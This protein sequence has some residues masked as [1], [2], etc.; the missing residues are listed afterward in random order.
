LQQQINELEFKL[1]NVSDELEASQERESHLNEALESKAPEIQIKV[2]PSLRLHCL[3]F[4]QDMLCFGYACAVNFAS[5]YGECS[6]S[7]P[8]AVPKRQVA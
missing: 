3:K 8:G 5:A 4:T 2:C 6:F 7:D 1:Q